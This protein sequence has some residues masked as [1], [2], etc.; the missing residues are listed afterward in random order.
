MAEPGGVL[1]PLVALGRDLRARGLP[2][3]TGRILTFCRS[4]AA[5]GVTD[6]DSLYWAG[7]VALVAKHE[8]LEVYDGAF[9]AWFRSLRLASDA[10]LDLELSMPV[11]MDIDLAALADPA[12]IQVVGTAAS[13]RAADDDDEP[14]PGDEATI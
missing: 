14:Q 5:L 1:G 7:R 3:G 4:V 2:V 13:W 9:D 11:D 10:R 12:E 8:D 6:R